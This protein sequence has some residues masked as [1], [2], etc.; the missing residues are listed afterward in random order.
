MSFLSYRTAFV[1]DN[2]GDNSSK[3]FT[4]LLNNRT[5]VSRRLSEDDARSAGLASGSEYYDGY[6]G[7]SQEVL[8]GSF[9][10]AYSW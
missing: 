8:I 7:V 9:L 4:E 3:T 2:K 1:K 6:N 5:V 10:A